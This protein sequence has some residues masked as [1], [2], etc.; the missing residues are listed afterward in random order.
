MRERCSTNFFEESSGL[1][2]VRGIRSLC[3]PAESLRH[4][5]AGFG[6]LAAVLQQACQAQGRTQLQRLRA[7]TPGDAEGPPEAGLRLG[8]PS[9]IGIGGRCDGCLS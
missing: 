4:Q 3:E 7:L 8:A 2:L 6:G 5:S 9:R 1:L